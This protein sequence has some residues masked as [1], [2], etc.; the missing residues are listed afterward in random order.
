MCRSQSKENLNLNNERWPGGVAPVVECL[1][2]KCE[3]LSSN[4]IA[5]VKRRKKE[6]EGKEGGKEGRKGGGRKGRRREGDNRCQRQHGIN[7]S[8]SFIPRTTSKQTSDCFKQAIMN[9]FLAKEK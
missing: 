9:K 4:P 5:A 8:I 3:A 7:V 1:P 2:R 6:E